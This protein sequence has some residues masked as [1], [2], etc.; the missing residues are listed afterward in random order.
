M[1]TNPA[2]QETNTPEPETSEA[3]Q[4]TNT[5]EPEVP[6][7]STL[8]PPTVPMPMSHGF[9]RLRRSTDD[10]IAVALKAR[11]ATRKFLQGKM[12]TDYDFLALASTS[13][14]AEWFDN[15]DPAGEIGRELFEAEFEKMFG[16]VFKYQQPCSAPKP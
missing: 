7:R 15:L 6:L 12:R 16:R 13:A 3:E 5:P 9:V 10:P 14:I 2:L 1:E 11:A 4:E 8:H